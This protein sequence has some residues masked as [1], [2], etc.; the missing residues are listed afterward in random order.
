MTVKVVPSEG[1]P[2]Q[3]FPMIRG[4]LLVQFCVEEPRAILGRSGGTDCDRPTIRVSGGRGESDPPAGQLASA[5]LAGDVMT[6]YAVCDGSSK[7]SVFQFCTG[8]AIQVNMKSFSEGY[9]V[10]R[11]AAAGGDATHQCQDLIEVS[12]LSDEPPA[13][14]CD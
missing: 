4:D 5:W 11:P 2:L 14:S 1:M 8:D 6:L 13:A 10:A 12:F 7:L 3:I 9:C